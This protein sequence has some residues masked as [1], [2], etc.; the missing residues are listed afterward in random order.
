MAKKRTLPTTADELATLILAAPV[1]TN[2]VKTG[3]ASFTNVW[4]GNPAVAVAADSLRF[5]NPDGVLDCDLLEQAPPA[6]ALIQDAL[7]KAAEKA[8]F[9]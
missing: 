2:I 6:L 1:R 5:R 7:P 3:L 8:R 9:R 4:D